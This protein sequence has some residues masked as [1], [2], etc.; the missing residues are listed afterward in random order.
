[1]TLILWCRGDTLAT[2]IIRRGKEIGGDEGGI[3]C[4]R[5]SSGG[6]FGWRDVAVWSGGIPGGNERKMS[7]K[8]PADHHVIALTYVSRS[9]NAVAERRFLILQFPAGVGAPVIRCQALG[10]RC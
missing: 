10:F 2:G 3:V 6:N 9:Q 8:R 5:D 7:Q 1:M 4:R